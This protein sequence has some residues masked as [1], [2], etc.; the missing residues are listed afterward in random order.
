MDEPKEE[1]YVLGTGTW[2]DLLPTLP[3]PVF[4]FGSKNL[5]RVMIHGSGFVLPIG[6]G[7][8]AIGFFTARF[9]TAST[10]PEA[11]LVALDRVA[12]EWRKRGYREAGGEATLSIDSTDVLYERFKL[13]RGIGFT[14]YS[15]SDE[16]ES[17]D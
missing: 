4:A 8:P 16:D 3:Q 9:V 12:T 7:S 10:R 5:Y 2:R 11:E 6:P 13:R 17:P 1:Y 14:F 15:D